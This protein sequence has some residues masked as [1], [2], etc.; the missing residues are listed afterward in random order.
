MQ[1]QMLY[2]SQT[3]WSG[4]KNFFIFNLKVNALRSFTTEVHGI[5][6][7]CSITVSHAFEYV[8]RLSLQRLK[9]YNIIMMFFFLF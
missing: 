7:E 4:L 1:V 3:I 5:Q 8:L 6:N 9:T 2:V